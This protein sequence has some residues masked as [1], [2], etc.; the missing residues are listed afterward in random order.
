MSE[1]GGSVHRT[2]RATV[3]DEITQR[4][5][6]SLKAELAQLQA[7]YKEAK[8]GSKAGLKAR[9]DEVE[10]HTR[11]TSEHLHTRVTRV[12]QETEAKLK[13]L[14][15]QATRASGHLKTSVEQRIAELR[16]DGER[17]SHQ[18]QQAWG[19]TKEALTS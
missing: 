16:V 11:A 12:A 5:M 3:E 4:Q 18:L 15:V 14:Q 6:A 19:L 10:A 1:L 8:A 7:E 2:A 13:A 9:I 17:R